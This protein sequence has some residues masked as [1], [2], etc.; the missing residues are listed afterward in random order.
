[1]CLGGNMRGSVRWGV[2]LGAAVAVLNLVFG[3]LGWHRTYEMSFVFLAVAILIN[4]ATVILCLRERA[5]SERWLGQLKN[6]FVVGLVGSVI[7]FV[8]SW[9]VTT[10][11][12]PD[13]FAEMA[14]G[15]RQAYVDM[16]LSEAEVSDWVAATAAT[17]PVRSAFDGVVGTIATSLVVAAIAGI[18]LRNKD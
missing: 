1:M 6:G 7:I 17:S 10:A 18:W 13:Y 12:F 16:G 15:Y 8:T 9:L 3:L 14:D 11:V 4:V 2:I 5:P